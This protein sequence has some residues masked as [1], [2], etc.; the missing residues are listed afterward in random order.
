[1]TSTQGR[2]LRPWN[3]KDIVKIEFKL[4]KLTTIA[5]ITANGQ[6]HTDITKDDLLLKPV[7][8]R[9]LEME[10]RKESRRRVDIF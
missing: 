5:V 9:T 10:M 1:M 6:K 8:E 4:D 3:W 7:L 2:I